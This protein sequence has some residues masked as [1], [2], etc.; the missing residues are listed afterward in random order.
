MAGQTKGMSADDI[1]AF[2]EATGKKSEEKADD[3]KTEK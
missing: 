3:N 1:K 2:A